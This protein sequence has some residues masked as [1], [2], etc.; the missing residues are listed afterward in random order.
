M[1]KKVPKL[2]SHSL[3]TNVE[4][5]SRFDRKTIKGVHRLFRGVHFNLG[6]VQ[7]AKGVHFER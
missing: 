2:L 5:V 4:K 3:G 6:G 7:M 1:R